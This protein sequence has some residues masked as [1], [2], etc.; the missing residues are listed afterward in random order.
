MTRPDIGC[1]CIET[2]IH[3]AL[4]AN[5]PSRDQLLEGFRRD[6]TGPGHIPEEPPRDWYG[7]EAE[8]RRHLQRIREV[9]T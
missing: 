5:G 9:A 7:K 4:T 8:F 2:G 1:V 3:C 6:H